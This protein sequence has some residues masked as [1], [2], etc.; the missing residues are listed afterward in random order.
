[1]LI[2]ALSIFPTGLD[3]SFVHHYCLGARMYDTGQCQIGWAYM[4]AMIGTALAIFSPFLAQYTD[5]TLDERK[6]A[7]IENS[8]QCKPPEYAQVAPQYDLPTYV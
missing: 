4:L 1:M 2:I 3:S 5:I 6:E 8:I 7:T